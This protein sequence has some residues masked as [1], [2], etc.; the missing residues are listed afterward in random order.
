[1]QSPV[2]RSQKLPVPH[3]TSVAQP[4]HFEPMQTSGAQL[5]GVDAGH[6][7]ALQNA[8]GVTLL[9]EASHE[10]ARHSTEPSGT[11][12]ASVSMPLHVPL[13]IGSVPGHRGR[14]LT[15]SPITGEQVPFR[16]TRL[17]DSHWPLHGLLQQTPSTQNVDAHCPPEV[18]GSPLSILSLQ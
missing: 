17:Q 14:G 9:L 6:E 10:A 1:L 2:A 5:V 18:H 12:H 3:C 11:A 13:Q 8:A 7:P 15:G 16:V 4:L